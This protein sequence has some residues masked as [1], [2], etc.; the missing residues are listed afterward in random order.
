MRCLPPSPLVVLAAAGLLL[1]AC[2]DGGPVAAEPAT[3]ATEP[4][5]QPPSPDTGEGA[6]VE[7]VDPV[8]AA[9][10]LAAVTMTFAGARD[11]FDPVREDAPTAVGTSDTDDA[12]PA[13]PAAPE[14]TEGPT[15]VPPA[16]EPT[17][18]A[19][20][21]PEPSAAS[22]ETELERCLAALRLLDAGTGS[23]GPA[24]IQL[25]TTLYEVEV[26]AGFADAF[27]LV[28]LEDGCATIAHRD[29]VVEICVAPDGSLK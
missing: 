13:A 17:P 24:V 27:V 25:G 20:P 14:P 28:R 18:T 22:C 21:T 12:V 11:P 29:G 16:V 23:D 4:V 5:T 15:Q 8:L 1:G 2:S 9:E 7:A 19:T 26:G 3:A 6:G 10:E